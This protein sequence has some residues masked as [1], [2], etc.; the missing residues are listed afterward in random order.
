MVVPTNWKTLRARE[1]RAQNPEREL[2]LGAAYRA[3]H[4][5]ELAAR[6]RK[7]NAARAA[8]EGR[9]LKAK[10]G[11]LPVPARVD[12][13]AYRRELYLLRKAADPEG[14]LA[15]LRAQH[16]RQVARDPDGYLQRRRDQIREAKFGL[17]AEAYA[18]LVEAQGGV[19]AICGH[20]ETARFKGRLKLLAVDHDHKTGL[21]RGLLCQACNLV[22]GF[23]REDVGRLEAA[24]AYLRR[25]S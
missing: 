16:A 18:G 24:I 1:R 21:N 23:A 12:P 9:T 11:S 7:R 6:A 15:R 8:A 4:R 17:S 3:R 14:H 22:I 13:N 19:C 10:R 25:F 5:S 20:V 2:A